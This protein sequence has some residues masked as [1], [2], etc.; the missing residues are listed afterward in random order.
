M[1]LFFDVIEKEDD[2]D[3]NISPED[4]QYEEDE[5]FAIQLQNIERGKYRNLNPKEHTDM[6][7]KLMKYQYGVDDPDYSK[8]IK[9]EEEFKNF[10]ETVEPRNAGDEEDEEM[11]VFDTAQQEEDQEIAHVPKS[12]PSKRVNSIPT[13]LH[14]KTIQTRQGKNNNKKRKVK[15]NFGSS[16]SRENNGI[17]FHDEGQGYALITEYFGARTCKLY[18][19]TTGEIGLS[20]YLLKHNKIAMRGDVVLY[21]ER[22][23]QKNKVDIIYVYS[24]S[25]RLELISGKQLKTNDLVVKVPIEI[26]CM[27]ILPLLS[28]KRFTFNEMCKYTIFNI[29]RGK[30]RKKI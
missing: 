13:S 8:E 17:L 21:R 4:L 22:N 28:K 1:N 25:E 7:L 3:E 24:D 11:Y 23:Y 12:H 29:H 15:N 5:K 18:S 6:E 2:D 14:H 30:F 19:Y 16:T 20:G 9:V 27:Y 26:I 10:Y